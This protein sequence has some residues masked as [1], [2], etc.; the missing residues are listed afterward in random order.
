MQTIDIKYKANYYSLL[1]LGFILPLYK[2][3]IPAGIFLFAITSFV[4]CSPKEEIIKKID[5][6]ILLLFSLFT[7]YL[8]SIFYSEDKSSGWMN[9][10]TK[11]SFFIF[12][13]ALFFSNLEIKKVLP[14]VLKSFLEGC[15]IA[16]ILLLANGFS[17][18]YYTQEIDSFFYSKLS[19]FSHA[20]YFSM[21]LCFSLAI[22]YYYSFK[23]STEFYI[24]P[25][26]SFLLIIIFSTIIILLASKSGWIILLLTHILALIFWII[27][28]KQFLKGAIAIGALFLS[29]VLFYTYSPSLKKRVDELTRITI[30]DTS[31]KN[32]SSTQV[33]LVVWEIAIQLIKEKPLF[34]YGCG[35]SRNILTEKYK[36]MNLEKLM[37]K[38]LNAHNQYLQ[39]LLD[40]GI[41]GAIILLTFLILPL[42]YSFK[43]KL[44][45]YSIFIL[46]IG[47]NFMS[48][49][50]LETQSGVIFFAFFNTLFFFTLI[51]QININNVPLKITE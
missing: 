33:R 17:Q 6:K 48:E 5:K 8:I 21:Y 50:M 13:L 45:L 32:L 47:L 12:P 27:K 10:E 51:Q 34:G 20:S 49:A 3:I 26:I 30:K 44:W 1:I 42:L 9:I 38:R 37:N 16:I 24:K 19:I 43:Y 22:L 36:E 7:I 41:I 11:L 25:L 14:T 15:L 35:D 40:V 39:T 4:N 31:T 18:Y 23:P 28:H 46:I 2:E 29:T